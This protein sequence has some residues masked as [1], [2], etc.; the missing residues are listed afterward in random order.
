[1]VNY[2]THFQRLEKYFHIIETQGKNQDGNIAEAAFQFWISLKEVIADFYNF[3][4]IR[5]SDAQLS[6]VQAWINLVLSNHNIPKRIREQISNEAMEFS[7]MA[8][9]IR[10]SHED[11]IRM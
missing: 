7:A 8:E 3:D 4:K 2:S 11:I 6:V 1:M 10:R 9:K 5:L